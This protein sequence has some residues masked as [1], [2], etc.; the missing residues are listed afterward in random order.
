M[1]RVS[2]SAG[3]SFR[4]WDGQSTA[5]VFDN[6]TVSTHLVGEVAVAILEL[7]KVHPV[8]VDEIFAGLFAASPLDSSITDI[9]GDLQLIDQAIIGLVA[10]GLLRRVE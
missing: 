3:L 10:A 6:N 2:A 5:A 9:G 7:A 8:T 1:S 4:R